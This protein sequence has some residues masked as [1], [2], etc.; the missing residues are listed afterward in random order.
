MKLIIGTLIFCIV[1]FLY[2]HIQFHLKTSD[3]LEIYEI[4]QASKD[5]LEEICDLRQP[6]MFDL[7]NPKLIETTN[8]EYILKN[9]PVFEVKIR[10]PVDTD[11]VPLTLEL[12]NVLFKEDTTASYFSENNEDFLLETGINKHMQYND[13]FLRPPMVS[14]CYY[15]ILMG[16]ESATTPFRYELNYRTFLV[17]T[18]GSIQIKMSPPKSGRY[19]YPVN[20][21]DTFEFRSQINPWS[22]E[23]KYR[24][25]F[26]KIKCLELTLSP[27]KCL[28][29]PAYWWYSIRFGADTSIS[30]LS[31]RTYMNNVAILPSTIMYLLQNQNIKRDVVK[32]IDISKSQ[33]K[34]EDKTKKVKKKEKEKEKEKENKE[35]E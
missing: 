34:E 24:A 21:Y 35:P 31:Y 6:V 18:Q 13:E 10:S 16:T 5:K 15:D 19:L 26:D 9:Y 8:K 27:G 25:D 33:F 29:I 22:V 28:F 17:V 11:H 3:D 23:A 2:L 14:N 4:D 20:D 7:E 30:M 1:L 12:A 32:K